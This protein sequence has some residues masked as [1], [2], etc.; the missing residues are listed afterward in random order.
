MRYVGA[1]YIPVY[2]TWNQGVWDKTHQYEQLEI[3]S[4]NGNYYISGTIVPPG[5]DITNTQY[6][7]YNGT[8]NPDLS[9]INNKYNTLLKRATS[10]TEYGAKGDGTTDDSTAIQNAVNNGG[11]ILFPPGLYVIST[12]IA[13]VSNSILIGYG[14]RITRN[15][16]TA[17]FSI[18]S[19]TDNTEKKNITIE[20]VEI[21]SPS[22]FTGNGIS[23]IQNEPDDPVVD[24]I[25]LINLYIHDLPSG[26][27]VNTFAG[28]PGSAGTHP[29]PKITVSHCVIS[30]CEGGSI[31]NS[32]VE[33]TVEDCKITGKPTIE[34]ITFDNGCQNSKLINCYV[35]GTTGGAGAVSCDENTNL[36][37]HDNIIIQRKSGMPAINIGAKSGNTN[38]VTLVNNVLT[39]PAAAFRLMGDGTIDNLLIK[40][41]KGDRIVID[42]INLTGCVDIDEIVLTASEAA[43]LS[44][45]S[46]VRKSLVY[47]MDASNYVSEGFSAPNAPVLYFAGNIA[48]LY[49]N[50]TKDSGNFAASEVLM[51]LPVKLT[52]SAFNYVDGNTVQVGLDGNLTING[53]TSVNNLKASI[54]IP[55]I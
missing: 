4:Y 34:L 8:F 14:A 28:G 2:S 38:G 24:N 22:S 1:R 43:S 40:G 18:D 13:L 51:Q 6:W 39:S 45:I 37:V 31:I 33:V 48:M 16:N 12:R 10:V 44:G 26:R 49:F 50:I 5:V 54:M 9:D 15:A 21:F 36:Q 42:N 52:N 23:I 53:F 27:G 46:A 47:R 3:V 25:H 30:D 41:N 32:G 55:L 7:H 20:G 29:Y 17:F 19:R 11:I 35:D